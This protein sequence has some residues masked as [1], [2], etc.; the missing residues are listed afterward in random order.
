MQVI[1]SICTFCGVGCGIGLRVEHGRVVGVEP[2]P[3]HPVSQGQLC[4]KGWSTSFA[5]DPANRLREPLIKE[6]GQ[7]RP[8]TWDEALE[9]IASEFRAAQET[10][11]ADGVGVISCARATNE[12]NYAAQKFARAVLGTNNVDHCARICHSP[13]VAGLARTLG[14]GAMTNSIADIDLAELILVIGADVTENHAMIG[15]RMLRAQA[16]GAKLVVIDP[17]KTR[18]AR[19]ADIHLQLRLGSNVA[20]LNGLLQIIFANGW[21]NAA[22]LAER[23]EDITPLRRHLAG[24]TPEQTSAATGIPVADLLRV[25]ELFSHSPAAFTAWGMGITQFQSGTNN[26]IAVSNLAL[27]CGQVG[28]PGTGIN[29]L[30]GQN[31]VQGACDMGCLPNVYPGYQQAD[32][33]AVQAKFAQAWGAPMPA[34]PGL[35]SLGMTRAALDGNLRALMIIGEDPVVTDPDQRQVARSL[36]ALDFLVVFELTLTET[37]KMADVVLP[38]ASF[39]E[40]DGTF[41]NCERRVQRIRKAVGAPGTAR[42]DWQILGDLAARMGYAGMDW[43]SA[44]AVFDEMAAV[45]P[46]FSAM[47]YAELDARHGLH[48]PCDAEHPQGSPL[49]HA[50]S[51]PLGRARLIP[52]SQVE[53]A[54]CPDAEYPWLFTTHRFHFHYNCGSMTRK[55]PLLE[56]ETPAGLVLMNP[57][58]AAEHGYADLQAVRVSSR[59]GAVE[60]RLQLTDDLPRGMLAMPYHFR[61]APCNRL[62]N[63]AMDPVSKMPELKACAVAIEPLPA[64]AAPHNRIDASE[65]A[66]AS[67]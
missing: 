21:E 53:P 4:A 55:S 22:F 44:E 35:T 60:A 11:G 26:V 9:R 16:R 62:T 46:I 65:V 29:P 33:P 47:S 32:A 1:P 40:K 14:S 20:L 8:A 7:F 63:D 43:D 66:H 39:V 67:L 15:A 41:T 61:E 54:E 31:N 24:I 56:R 30:R 58:D 13:S 5:I 45:A 64:G 36:Q 12:D 50:Q 48:W 3:G 57:L 2:Q 52:V 6:H 19:L 37:A 42:C 38:A 51:F 23:C 28:R 27:A 59:R 49:L 25:A 10:A 34:R 18:L 17:R